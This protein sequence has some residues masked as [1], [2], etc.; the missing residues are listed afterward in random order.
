VGLTTTSE[1]DGPA[2]FRFPAR[3]E[4]L[5]GRGKTKGS[6]RFAS[7]LLDLCTAVAKIRLRA[8]ARSAAFVSVGYG[9]VLSRFGTNFKAQVEPFPTASAWFNPLDTG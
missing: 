7:Q 9:R 3:V 6:Y 1:L 8:S 2:L 5:Q 4:L